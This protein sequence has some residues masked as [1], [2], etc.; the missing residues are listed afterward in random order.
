M[1]RPN[2]SARLGRGL[3]ITIDNEKRVVK[4]VKKIL[5]LTLA[6]LL[7]IS[8]PA[9][10]GCGCGESPPADAFEEYYQAG[11]ERTEPLVAFEEFYNAAREGDY[12]EVYG[13]LSARYRGQFTLEDVEKNLEEPPEIVLIESNVDAESDSGIISYVTKDTGENFWVICVRENGDWKI[14]ELVP[15]EKAE[16]GSSPQPSVPQP[17]LNTQ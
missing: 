1:T 14:D 3:E 9:V 12:E 8:I 7:L 6:S 11:G 10:L 2:R 17:D 13:L 4:P 15:A 16:P 5:V